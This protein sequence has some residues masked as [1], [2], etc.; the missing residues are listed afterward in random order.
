MIADALLDDLGIAG[1]RELGVA[2]LEDKAQSI[3][4]ER[5][6]GGGARTEGA[7]KLDRPLP[8]RSYSSR[9]LGRIMN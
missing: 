9:Y 5:R 3:V 6:A 2:G 1:I 4:S 8:P 7:A